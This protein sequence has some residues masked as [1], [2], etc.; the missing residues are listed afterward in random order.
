MKKVTEI[1]RYIDIINEMWYY[2]I[3]FIYMLYTENI[4]YMM[5]Y[6]SVYQSSVVC[7][8]IFIDIWCFICLYQNIIDQNAFWWFHNVKMVNIDLL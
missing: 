3:H 5:L 7:I 8:L 1:Y 6:I 4:L 2:I